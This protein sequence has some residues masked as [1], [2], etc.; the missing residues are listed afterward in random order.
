MLAREPRP[1]EYL[2]ACHPTLLQRALM[3]AVA[4]PGPNEGKPGA[5]QASDC[6]FDRGFASLNPSHPAAQC[7]A[8]LFLASIYLL[9][10]RRNSSAPT[11][12]PTPAKP[13]CHAKSAELGDRSTDASSKSWQNNAP[14]IEPPITAIAADSSHGVGGLL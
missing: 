5:W 7:P 12:T 1:S 4:W 8:E 13:Y 3:N 6:I 2:R 11:T 10:T 9:P 14:P